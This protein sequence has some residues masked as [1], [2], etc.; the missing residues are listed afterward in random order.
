[1]IQAAVFVILVFAVP[2]IVAPWLPQQPRNTFEVVLTYLPGVW[3]P[4]VI[5]VGIILA[6]GG[7][8]NL[9]REIASRFRYRKRD[10]VS[11]LAAATI[12]SLVTMAGVLAA[13]ASGDGQPFIAAST[14]GSVVLVA[15]TTGAVGEEF[16]WRGFLLSRLGPRLSPPLA[17]VT[18]AVLW[19][20]WHL[21][22]FLFPDS[23]YATWP[24]VPALLT[25]VSFGLFMA[26]LFHRTG[27]SVIPT[28]LAHLSLNISLSLGGASLSS[29]VLWWTIAP[30]YAVLAYFL[31]GR[32]E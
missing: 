31:S 12:P 4:T 19:G 20:L 29:P 14:V 27:G 17:A 2:W 23:P 5:A 7:L 28:I 26:S 25:I 32:S 30:I 10:G 8:Q 21:P 22:I 15:A 6:V 18:M 24:I 1:M 11:F 16:G 9:W 3:A 13:R